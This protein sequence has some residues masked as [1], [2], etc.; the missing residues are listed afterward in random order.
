M[1]ANTSSLNDFLPFSRLNNNEFQTYIHQQSEI[2]LND[3]EIE[4][5][6]NLSFNPFLQSS[7][8]KTCLTLNPDLDPDQNY[9]NE[10]MTHIEGCDYHDEDTFHC[11]TKDS[12]D[13]EFSIL[14]LNIRSILN[15]FDDLKAYLSSLE[16]KFSI[17]G[18]SETWLNPDNI[19]E[20][21]LTNYHNIGKVRTNKQGGGVGLYVNRSLQFRERT[22]LAINME[23]VI[24]SHFIELTT[25]PSNTLIGIIYRPP[26]NKLDLFK[27]YL[28][29]LLQ[30]LALQ[31]KKCYLM[32]DFNLEL[33]KMGE[34]HHIKD[35]INL[36]FSSM[37]YPL[38]SKPTRITN[39][40]ATLI[41]N[42]FVNNF[43][44]CY[45]CGILLTD[46]SDHLPVFQITS[47]LQRVNSTCDNTKYKLINKKA[48][49]QLCQD[50]KIED[51]N[52][53][54]NEIDPN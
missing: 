18:L 51:W 15:K 17:I 22:D 31:K 12:K 39:S 14:H 6:R 20:F 28:C 37:F 16:Y 33:L 9:Y 54:Y 10:I 35:F 53:I 26:N 4:R 5:L 49:D 43:D 27:E 25:K 13:N 7:H 11:M 50:L 24:E 30:K 45:K 46:L 47:S 1:L 21:P 52:D 40:S 48:I 23:D 42:I 34:N 3:N 32:G 38:T 8:G 44:E 19:N 41:D 2:D 36:M 29:E